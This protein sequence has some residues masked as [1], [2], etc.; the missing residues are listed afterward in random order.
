MKDGLPADSEKFN[1]HFQNC[2]FLFFFVFFALTCNLFD[3][4][5]ASVL[6]KVNVMIWSLLK[7]KTMGSC[8][9][10]CNTPL[11]IYQMVVPLLHE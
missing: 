11:P 10:Q 5:N 2:F 6:M 1:K 9:I 3:G 7:E 4:M 8:E